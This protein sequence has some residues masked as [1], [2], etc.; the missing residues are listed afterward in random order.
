MD[1]ELT[2]L[3]LSEKVKEYI[4]KVE[5]ETNREVYIKG[6]Q[7]VGMPGMAERFKVNCNSKNIYVEIIELC[8]CDEK[9]NLKQ[10]QEE[11]DRSIAHEVTHGRLAYKEKYCQLRLIGNNYNLIDSAS[12][13][14]SSI[15]DIVVNTIIKKNSFKPISQSYLNEVVKPAT[16]DMRKRKD[17]FERFNYSP[18][19]RKS[20]MMSVYI[21]A[22]GYLQ[23][24][25]LGNIDKKNLHKLL[26]EFH[27]L[28]LEESKIAEKITK[29]ILDK[30][31]NIF[32]AKG[33]NE[34]IKKCLDLWKLT[35]LVRLYTC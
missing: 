31:N 22:W 25:N 29:T 34:V 17:I 23:Y 13:L 32:T 6:V 8:Y 24:F 28:Y 12:L 5:D 14:T 11:I 27:K 21:Q 4:K 19:L 20:F 15:E 30:D 1:N 3:K 7:D 10:E 18:I 9:G 16:E 26:K 35:D 33:Y 2:I